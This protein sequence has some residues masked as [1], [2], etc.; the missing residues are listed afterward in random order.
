LSGRLPVE[1]VRPK[2]KAE[3]KEIAACLSGKFTSPFLRV[4]FTIDPKG[5]VALVQTDYR[6]PVGEQERTCV[7]TALKKLKFPAPEGNGTVTAVYNAPTRS[8]SR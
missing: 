7:S 1:A 8:K 6:V 4:R 3:E 2:L 5:Q